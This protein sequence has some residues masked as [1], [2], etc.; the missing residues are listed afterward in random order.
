MKRSGPIKRKTPLRRVSKKRRVSSAVYF[1]KRRKF[2]RA[3]DICQVCNKA[4]SQE[5]HHKRGRYG[6]AYLDEHTWLA[7]CRPCHRGIHENPSESRKL[8][9]L[10]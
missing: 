10:A 2:L 3:L 8:G 1:D 7:V 4:N 9:L 5:V 6:S